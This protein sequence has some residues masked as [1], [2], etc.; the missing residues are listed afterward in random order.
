MLP[1]W[2]PPNVSK[3][4]VFRSR[5]LGRLSWCLYTH[6]TRYKYRVWCVIP[7]TNRSTSIIYEKWTLVFTQTLSHHMKFMRIGCSLP[8]IHTP[9]C[10]QNE[11]SNDCGSEPKTAHSQMYQRNDMPFLCHFQCKKQCKISQYTRAATMLSSTLL[12][13]WCICLTI[14]FET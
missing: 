1:C 3:Q 2:P 12:D 9:N 14:H 8:A 11:Q 10:V 13:V 7:K 6:D 5:S 4:D